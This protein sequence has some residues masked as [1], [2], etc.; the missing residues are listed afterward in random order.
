MGKE[1]LAEKASTPLNT[2]TRESSDAVYRAMDLTAILRPLLLMVT[3]ETFAALERNNKTRDETDQGRERLQATPRGLL[4]PFLELPHA[5]R[6]KGGEWRDDKV[7]CRNRSPRS[8]KKLVP[9]RT[10]TDSAC[11]SPPTQ[12]P[13]IYTSPL[14]ICIAF[15][16]AKPT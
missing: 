16:G 7:V 6:G 14:Q 8:A 10:R 15:P 3:T 13:T 4:S 5:Y 12:D 9:N 11:R 2:L 1:T